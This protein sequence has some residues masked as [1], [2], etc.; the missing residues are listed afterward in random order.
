MSGRLFSIKRKRPAFTLVEL[1]VVIAIIGVLVALLLPAVQAA[2]EAARKTQ[3]SNNLKQIALGVLNYEN[4][5]G[6]FPV[7]IPQ[8]NCQGDD[9]DMVPSGVSWMVRILPLVEQGTLY[10]TMNLDGPASSGRGILNPQNRDVIAKPIPLYL[11]PSDS[12][13]ED[14]AVQIDVWH[15]PK[16]YKIPL[17]TTNY[18]GVIGPHDPN[19]ASSFG[20]L[21]YCNNLCATMSKGILECTGTFWRHN[22]LVPV[23]VTS[24]EDGTSKTIIVGEI[25]PRY[26]VFRVWAISNSALAFTHAPINYVDRSAVGTWLALDNMG[27]HSLHPGGANF[28]WADGRV[29][30]LNDEIDLAVYRG[31]STRF[32]GESVMPP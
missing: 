1:L 13:D 22:Y 18:A 10:E 26:D 2:R 6:V 17:A 21:P 7:N 25:V 27:F 30:F 15:Y 3:C 31:L 23:T 14:D 12:R 28:A 29:S 11:C 24:F 4:Q 20:G 19:N 32:G 8:D 5:F 16:D 9:P